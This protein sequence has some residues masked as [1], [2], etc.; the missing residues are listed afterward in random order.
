MR[1]KL[2]QF[3][4]DLPEKLIA[5]YPSK[6]RDE[7][8]LMV[9]H[10]KTGQ[11]E[12][13]QFKDILEYFDEGDCMIFNNTKV[14][15]ARLYG[16]K[17]KTDAEI[18]VFLLRELNAKAR[19]WDVLVD[20]AR[21]I[22][23]GNKLYFLDK[24]GNEILVAEVV[25]NTTS[26]GRTIRFLFDGPDEE[27]NALLRS[28]GQTPL[29]KYINRKAEEMDKE[30]YQ[31]IYAQEEGA[32]AA[33]TAGLHFT[34]ELMKRLEIK[35]VDFAYLTLHVGLGTFRSID[36]E[37]LSKHK[38]DAEYFRITDETAEH[39]NASKRAGHKVCVVCTTSMRAVESAVSASGLLKPAEGWTNK[40]IYPPSDFSLPDAM[41]TNFHMPKSS[42]IIMVSAFGGHE[43][44]MDAYKK[45][46]KEKYRFYTYGD[47]M[48]IL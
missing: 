35:G 28:Q 4:F 13:R 30:R 1:T 7:S 36:V 19:L 38:M 31:T 17:E 26:R 18:E 2:S 14:F 6:E 43:L 32:V 24:K 27:F 45:A 25:D 48:L 23:V 15:P 40:F 10:R 8:K 44:I 47:A 37:D 34:R 41:I 33:P 12:T 22:R 9:V 29:P 11:L 5:K 21:K 39:V 42:L 46:V 20:P 3:S 16:R